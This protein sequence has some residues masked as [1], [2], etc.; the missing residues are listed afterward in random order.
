[1]NLEVSNRPFWDDTPPAPSR[2]STVTSDPPIIEIT[3]P[4]ARDGSVFNS[5]S[6][7]STSTDTKYFKTPDGVVHTQFR[8]QAKLSNATSLDSG[9]IYH[10][11]TLQ[12]SSEIE[13]FPESVYDNNR[14]SV[15]SVAHRRISIDS[16]SDACNMTDSG[17]PRLQDY[18]RLMVSSKNAEQNFTGRMPEEFNRPRNRFNN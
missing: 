1:M 3:E 10:L 5:E 17:N 4:D 14:L 15:P 8:L 16:R 13:P 7:V 18:I 2:G 11:S 6:V 12:R 9:E